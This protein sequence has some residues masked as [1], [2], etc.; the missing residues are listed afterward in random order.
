MKQRIDIAPPKSKEEIPTVPVIGIN[1]FDGTIPDAF[2]IFLSQINS[3]VK[4]N[5]CVSAADANVLVSSKKDPSFK[6]ILSNTFINLCDGMPGVWI[7]KMKGA[8]HID[9]CYGPDFFEYVL[10]ESANKNIN[11]YFTGGREGIA[12]KL[13]E[14]CKNKFNNQNVVG[15]HCPPFRELTEEEIKEIA[16]DINT[17]NTD[18]VWVGI[19]SPKQE[20][21]AQRLAKYTNV[22]FFVTVGAA[23]DFH[24]GNI[25]QAP[26][27]IQRSGFEWLYR[28]FAEPKRQLKKYFKVVPMYI[29]YNLKDFIIIKRNKIAK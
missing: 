12:E 22:H 27:T 10:N 5:Y 6:K 28:V 25:K 26:K 29:Y 13:Q 14:A 8:K 15:T 19:S 20:R 17:K 24:T 23:F 3:G 7:G 2:K 1:L 4:M 16:E 9:R 18:I 11:H 21:Y